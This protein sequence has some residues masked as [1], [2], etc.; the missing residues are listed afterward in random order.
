MVSDICLKFMNYSTKFKFR[1]LSFL[2]KIGNILHIGLKLHKSD[3]RHVV[4]FVLFCGK[5]TNP[6]MGSQHTIVWLIIIET[7]N[8]YISLHCYPAH[9][10]H[11]DTKIHSSSAPMKTKWWWN[12]NY[13]W[14]NN[15]KN[16]T[17]LPINF[18]NITHK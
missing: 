15:N 18:K 8:N 4:V 2:Q 17:L 13:E 3:E 14:Y 6:W 7:Y 16:N 5:T 10:R 1:E 11:T 9:P 12:L